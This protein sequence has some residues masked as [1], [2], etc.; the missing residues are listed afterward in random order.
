MKVPT[1]LD[2]HEGPCPLRH[3]RRST[4]PLA[5]G[6]HDRRT[7]GR[8]WPA[9][10]VAGISDPRARRGMRHQITV[11]LALAVCAALAGNRSFSVIGQWAAD[12]SDQVKAALQALSVPSEA[13]IRRTLQ[14]LDGDEMDTAIGSW[15]AAQT[16]PEPSSRRLIDRVQQRLDPPPTTLLGSRSW[17]SLCSRPCGVATMPRAGS[18][19]WRAVSSG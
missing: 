18:R 4:L 13:C 10:D 6:W 9:G 2:Q 7:S 16:S 1:P 14:R 11:I 17:G 5:I 19:R 15:A 8:W 3:Q 12:A